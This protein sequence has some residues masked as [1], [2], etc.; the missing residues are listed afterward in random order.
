MSNVQSQAGQKFT[1]QLHTAN[2]HHVPATPES[3]DFGTS[4][5]TGQAERSPQTVVP[6]EVAQAAANLA[7]AQ[8]YHG[9]ENPGT[10][11]ETPPRE[12]VSHNS[13]PGEACEDET[14]F[15]FMGFSMEQEVPVKRTPRHEELPEPP[16][17][18]NRTP[19]TQDEKD[20]VVVLVSYGH[21]L[22]QAAAHI[23]RTHVTL[24]RHLKK[25]KAFAEKV[26]R[27]RRYAES[28]AMREVVAASRKSWRAAAWL[29]EY[30][31]RRERALVG[32]EVKPPKPPKSQ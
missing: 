19:L 21:S 32:P 13:S 3:A 1:S 20:R 17:K 25:D 23:G 31:G 11:E 9:A 30:L 18:K 6:Q 24:S 7:A 22:R 8:M 14:D 28:D 5:D 15:G 12:E 4:A 2:G 16:V 29:L 26:E 27:Y 10:S